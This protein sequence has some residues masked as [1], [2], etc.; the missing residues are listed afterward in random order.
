M[1]TFVPINKFLKK[2]WPMHQMKKQWVVALQNLDLDS[3]TW[4][5]PLFS[6]KFALYDSGDKLWVPLLGL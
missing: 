5:A 1:D 2:D 6:K 4:K 3:V